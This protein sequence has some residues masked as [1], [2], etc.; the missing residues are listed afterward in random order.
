MSGSG[1][2]GVRGQIYKSKKILA[3]RLVGYIQVWAN[4]WVSYWLFCALLW[5]IGVVACSSGFQL[6]FHG[7]SKEFWCICGRYLNGKTIEPLSPR[8]GVVW[9]EL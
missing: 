8:V 4:A 9:F 6:G 5:A 3:G 7:V 1:R 2:L